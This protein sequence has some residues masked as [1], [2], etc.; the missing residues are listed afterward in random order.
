MPGLLR[1]I[2]RFCFRLLYN[3]MALTYDWVS[4]FVSM[5][6]WRSW[7]RAA[8]PYLRGR[9]VLEVAHGTGNLLL[10]MAALGFEPVGLDLSPAMGRLACQKL[11][12]HGMAESIPLVR[13]RAQALPFAAD[14]FPSVV[15]TFPTEFIVDPAAIAEFH[16]VLQ[17]GGV[18]VFV[19]VAQITGLSLPDRWARWLFQVTGQ[20]SADW[21]APLLKRYTDAG[22]SARAER[23]RLPR[24]LVTV[25]VAE[26]SA[27]ISGAPEEIRLQ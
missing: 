10:D 14:S 8:L 2:L 6:Q 23:V 25:I 26:K 1:L 13:G 17:S 5:G 19:P 16:R 27:S 22:F 18:V 20:A 24:S 12:T 7:Q 9:Q 21:F 11:R 4:G 15:S 3:E